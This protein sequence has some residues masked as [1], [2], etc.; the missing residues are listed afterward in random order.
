MI[1]DQCEPKPKKTVFF[2]RNETS[3]KFGDMADLEW[4]IALDSGKPVIK[5]PNC[6][7]AMELFKHRVDKDGT[8]KPLV[9]C[10]GIKEKPC[11][12]YSPIRL[13]GWRK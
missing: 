5:C 10:P 12:F 1:Q 2:T 3:E 4:C 13:L 8:V 11:D 6:K 7:E 9:I